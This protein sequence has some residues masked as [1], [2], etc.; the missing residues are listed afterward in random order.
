MDMHLKSFKLPSD[1]HGFVAT[2][3]IHQDNAIHDLLI[4]NF[5]IGLREGPGRVIS[6]HNYDHFFVPKHVPVSGYGFGHSICNAP[7]E[8]TIGGSWPLR[9]AIPSCN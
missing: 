6:R 2:A 9:Q 4:A 8:R 3:V 1:S 5:L 7:D